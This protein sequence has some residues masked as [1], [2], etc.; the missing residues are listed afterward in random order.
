[1]SD[2]EITDGFMCGR[3]KG[4][5]AQP[6]P[7]IAERRKPGL[8]VSLPFPRRPDTCQGCGLCLAPLDG[9]TLE[10][11]EESDEW[12]QPQHPPVLVILCA[13]C[14]RRVIEPHP[15]LYRQLD[16]NAPNLGAMA[17]CVGCKKREG[18]TCL[19]SIAR[20][21]GGPGMPIEYEKTP[22]RYH[23]RGGGFSGYRWLYSGPV[24]K[25]GGRE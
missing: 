14:S 21:N 7:P 15:R 9:V 17:L 22:T 24:I 10:V 25:C 20:Q 6:A 5:A 3:G 13:G 1:M 11:W 19:A 23:V 4:K 16:R 18:L 2:R 12:D 8:S